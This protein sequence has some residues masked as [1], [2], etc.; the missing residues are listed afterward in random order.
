MH[1]GLYVT[2]GGATATPLG[3]GGCDT[4]MGFV[5]DRE[6]TDQSDVK[7]PEEEALRLLL[8]GEVT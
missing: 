1:G 7:I 5:S 2:K 4:R 3:V 6:I 8:G